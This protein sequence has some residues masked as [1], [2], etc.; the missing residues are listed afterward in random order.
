MPKT[1]V[2]KHNAAVRMLE[3]KGFKQ[4]P[5]GGKRMRHPFFFFRDENDKIT[6]IKIRIV[7]KHSG[8]KGDITGKVIDQLRFVLDCEKDLV[9]GIFNCNKKKKDLLEHFREKEMI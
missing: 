5:H 2:F 1:P 3:S 4:S 9:I 8:G 7:N 6:Q